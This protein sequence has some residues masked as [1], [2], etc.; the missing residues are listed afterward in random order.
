MVCILLM[1]LYIFNSMTPIACSEPPPHCCHCQ[2]EPILSRTDQSQDHDLLFELQ[3]YWTNFSLY[4]T[5]PNGYFDQTMEKAV[6]NFQK[7]HH[8]KP[9]GIIDQETWQEIGS[10]GVK[11][12]IG[13]LPPGHLEVLVELNSLTLTVLIDRQPFRS[14]PVAIGKLETPSP[15]GSWKIVSKG[16]WVK[17]KTNWLGLS[18]PYGVYGIHGTNKPWSIGRRASNGCIRMFNHDLEVIYQWVNPGTRVF[19]EGDPFRDRRLLKRGLIGSD[20][21]YLQI[22]LKQLGYYPKKP[23][24]VFDYWTETALKECQADMGLPATGEMTT[25]EYYRLRLYPTD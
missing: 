7:L 9:S 14:F 11:H 1:L 17:G 23:N 10:I 25:K 2:T 15:I 18:A 3:K 5:K 13:E 22:R 6:I 24:G 19:I 12:P 20:V 8:L 21:Y 4:N 16:Y